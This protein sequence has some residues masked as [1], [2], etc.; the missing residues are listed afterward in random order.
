ML[1][2]LQLLMLEQKLY[3]GPFGKYNRYRCCFK[4]M[5][6]TTTEKLAVAKSVIAGPGVTTIE[7]QYNEIFLHRRLDSQG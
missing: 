5:A 2:R 6:T 1:E 7:A 4:R 3:H